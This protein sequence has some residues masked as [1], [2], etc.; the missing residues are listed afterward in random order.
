MTLAEFNAL[1]KAKAAE[2]LATT[3]GSVCWQTKMLERMPFANEA[4]LVKTAVEVWYDQCGRNDWIEAFAQHPKI[5]D[6]KSL[7]ERFPA[8][9]Q[10]AGQE[11]QDVSSASEEILTQLSKANDLYEA[12]FEYIFIVFATGKTAAEMLRILQDRS[13]NNYEEELIIAM[14]EQLKVT[15][16]RF[17]KIINE[18]QWHTVSIG[19]LTTHVLDTTTGQPAAGMT[20]RL[21]HYVNNTWYTL[22][23]GVTNK[24]GRVGD[25]LPPEKNVLPGNYKMCFE[26]FNYFRAQGIEGL[27]PK[28]EIDFT[29]KDDSH[30]HVPLL[31]SPFGYS[32]YRGS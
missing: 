5:G 6:I 3:C 31:L 18:A 32:T 9:S 20:I 29:V 13:S 4:E 30:Y 17:K 8:T 10:L 27:Y 1:D 24:D 23:Q 2:L 7:A 26:T 19:Q 16:Q 21:K 25:F 22:A 11:Q 12:K 14:G 15:I 28:V